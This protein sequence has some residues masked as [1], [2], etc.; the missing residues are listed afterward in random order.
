MLTG[1]NP[2]TTDLHH[3]SVGE[4]V[5]EHTASYPISGFEKYRLCASSSKPPC[6]R[7]PCQ[8]RTHYNDT[9][10]SNLPSDAITHAPA[11]DEPD[12][13]VTWSRSETYSIRIVPVLEATTAITS[14]K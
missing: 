10:G 2:L 11:R 5:V 13:G 3:G 6:R 8:A 7:E 4:G 9:H 12:E 14:A 1:T